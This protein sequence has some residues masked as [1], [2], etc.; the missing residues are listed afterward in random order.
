MIRNHATFGFDDKILLHEIANRFSDSV[1]AVWDSEPVEYQK[2][3]F[4]QLS[5]NLMTAPKAAEKH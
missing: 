5:S 4:L 2:N 1:P 3:Y